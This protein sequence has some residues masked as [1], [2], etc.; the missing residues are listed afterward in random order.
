MRSESWESLSQ[1]IQ[2]HDP[3]CRGAVVLGLNQSEAE[4]IAK[5]KEAKHPIV[6]GFMIGRTVWAKPL[7]ALLTGKI[8]AEQAKVQMKECMRRLIDGWLNR[9]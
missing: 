1:L 6:K 4:L 2:Q 7:S 3:Y 8:N 9:K 5:F